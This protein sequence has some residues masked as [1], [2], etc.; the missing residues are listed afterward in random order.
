ML[1]HGSLSRY[2]A[3]TNTND[4][5]LLENH[6]HAQFELI[7]VFS[8]T[9]CLYPEGG[10]LLLSAGHAA[11]IPPLYYHA[12]SVQSGENYRRLTLL[13]DESMLP[14]PL[15]AP[16]SLLRAPVCVRA[17][18]CISRLEPILLSSRD[19]Y[20]APLSESLLTELFY[21]F[22]DRPE[23]KIQNENRELSEILI[24]IEEHLCEKIT[25]EDIARRTARSKSSVCHLFSEQMKT[26]VKQYILQKKLSYAEKCMEEGLSATDAAREIGYE[27]YSNF[28]RMYQKTFGMSPKEKSTASF[29]P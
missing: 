7:A 2:Y 8:G 25:L 26:S 22:A 1:F 28:Y 17:A 9:V 13:F 14:A 27:N 23:R 24:Y 10:T 18:D 15:R 19:E 3:E 6:C 29:R 16:F 11:L 20:Y 12:V 21:R 5:V 4:G